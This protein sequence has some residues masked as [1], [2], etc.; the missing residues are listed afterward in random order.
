MPL[1]PEEEKS[2]T[3]EKL[4]QAKRFIP[5]RLDAMLEPPVDVGQ[6]KPT[7][8][9]VASVRAKVVGQFA[10]KTVEQLRVRVNCES[11]GATV[12]FAPES[13]YTL[14]EQRAITLG[15]K[16]NI[17]RKAEDEIPA[18]LAEEVRMSADLIPPAIRAAILR[19]R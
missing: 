8:E 5:A 13:D 16:A 19:N 11:F 18:I 12:K 3:P 6:T 2:F 17:G 10:N 4:A 1:T 15:W 9:Q 7:P 14:T